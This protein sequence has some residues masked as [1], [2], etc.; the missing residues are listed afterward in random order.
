MVVYVL[1]LEQ[2]KYYVG[3]TRHLRYR[4]WQHTTG[5]GAAQWTRFYKP[6]E[7]IEVIENGTL[8]IENSTTLAYREI[9]GTGNVRGGSYCAGERKPQFPSPFEMEV[10]L[11]DDERFF[12]GFSREPD[13]EL[14]R[15]YS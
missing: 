2:G 7:L 8:D 3:I 5:Y 4:L 14:I 1:R 12:V 10:F 11:M 15:K 13:D 9:Y 6:I